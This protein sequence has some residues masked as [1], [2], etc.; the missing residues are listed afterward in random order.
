MKWL[1]WVICEN[2]KK[3]KIKKCAHHKKHI[4]FWNCNSSCER[5]DG[6]FSS[7]CAP[8]DEN[9]KLLKQSTEPTILDKAKDIVNI[10]RPPIDADISYTMTNTDLTDAIVKLG[11]MPT[12]SGYCS[13]W[14]SKK[15]ADQI[16]FLLEVQ[17][18][19]ASMEM[20]VCGPSVK[21]KLGIPKANMVKAGKK[22]DRLSGSC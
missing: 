11:N 4:G 5:E 19:R 8:C 22:N 2:A 9:G 15:I 13:T 10:I 3:C 7:R 17:R 21:I 16:K 18:K 6:I 1:N 12:G 14:I 20:Q